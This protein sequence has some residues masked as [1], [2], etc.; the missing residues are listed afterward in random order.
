MIRFDI[1][2]YKEGKKIQGNKE[3]TSCFFEGYQSLQLTIAPTSSIL[4]ILILTIA[5][6]LIENRHCRLA[7][8]NEVGAGCRLVMVNA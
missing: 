5:T 8:L 6:D 7:R 2:G 3:S 1:L 4:K